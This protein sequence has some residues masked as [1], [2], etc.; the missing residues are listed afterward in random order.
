MSRRPAHI[1][2]KFKA[3]WIGS[4]EHTEKAKKNAAQTIGLRG[5]VHDSQLPSLERLCIPADV[6]SDVN[7]CAVPMA[8]GTL[9]DQ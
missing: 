6:N 9:V 7:K 3:P 4:S 1:S 8:E 2:L 5:V